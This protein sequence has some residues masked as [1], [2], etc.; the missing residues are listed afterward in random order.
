[1]FWGFY[2]L[3]LTKNTQQNEKNKNK[4]SHNCIRS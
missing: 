2:K 1:M 4:Y 3:F